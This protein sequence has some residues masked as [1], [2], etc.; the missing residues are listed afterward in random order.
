MPS[1]ASRLHCRRGG[2]GLDVSVSGYRA[3]TRGGSPDRKRL[4]ASQR[5]ALIRAMHAELKRAYGSPRR[6][7]ELTARGFTPVAPNQVGT[8]DITY[9][10]I[11]EGWRSLAIVLALFNRDVVGWSRQP[12]KRP[13]VGLMPHSDR[14][15]PYASQSVQKKLKAYGM[16]CSMRPQGKRLGQC[17]DRK[18]VQQRQDRASAWH[19]RRDA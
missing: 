1:T 14:G 4:T 13:A 10:W 18:R 3:W 11:D 6:V 16:V 7:S 17:P 9:L 5:L 2:E 12:R 8:S 15:S 19:S